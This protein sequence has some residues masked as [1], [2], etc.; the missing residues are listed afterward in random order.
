MGERLL[1]ETAGPSHKSIHQDG[2]MDPSVPRPGSTSRKVTDRGGDIL[3]AGFRGW[4]KGRTISRED[5]KPR[6]RRQTRGGD[7]FP[8][9]A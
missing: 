1:C 7:A 4:G 5:A 8:V 9:D 6:R 3:V 2:R